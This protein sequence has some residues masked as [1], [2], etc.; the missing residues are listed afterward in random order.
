MATPDPARI[1]ARAEQVLKELQP[2][3]IWRAS[4]D[5]G[6]VSTKL[7]L[8]TSIAPPPPGDPTARL[9]DYVITSILREGGG[10][11]ARFA[12]DAETGALLEAEAVRKTG[13]VLRAYVDTEPIARKHLPEP[14]PLPVPAATVVWK[15][16]RESTSRFVPFWRYLIAGRTIFIRA[17]GAVFTEL[18]TTGRG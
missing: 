13:E 2:S 7:L 8:V 9:A 10:L 4:L 16:C 1:I 14:A 18:T 11:S 17:D 15:P 6:I 3:E 12:Q 5:K